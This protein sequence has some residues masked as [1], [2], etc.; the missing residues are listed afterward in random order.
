L[1]PYLNISIALIVFMGLVSGGMLALVLMTTRRYQLS[2]SIILFLSGLLAVTGVFSAVSFIGNLAEGL[3]NAIVLLI[4]AFALGYTLTT[5]SVLSYPSRRHTPVQK[6]NGGHT[7]VVCLAPGEPPSYGVESAS[8]RFALAEDAADVPPILL[9]P[10]YLRDLRAK[11]AS[12][13][14]SPYRNY[15]IELARK[16]QSRLDSTHKVYPAFY[17]DIPTLPQV[18][19]QAIEDGARRIVLIHVR[20]TDPPD[21]VKAGDLM[22]GIRPD[23]YD[24]EMVTAGPLYD[25]DLLPQI[26][27][28]RVIEAVAQV[29]DDPHNV[30]LLLVGRGHARGEGNNSSSAMRFVQERQFQERVRQA[31]VKV[32]FTESR[33]AVGWLRWNAPSVAE[34]FQG[35]VSAG[36]KVVLWMPSAFP[37]DG[38]ITLH[39]IPEQ[40][41]SVASQAGVKLDALG[42]WNAD[43]LTAE[44]VAARV[45]AVP[46]PEPAPAPVR[47]Q[48]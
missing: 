45:R 42:A 14:S 12:L 20:V 22:E 15:Y 47:S 18:V 13:G 38:V 44:E 6:G 19:T 25:S 30:G 5:F 21:A 28:R 7:V 8:R 4:L 1:I 32:G 3:A 46:S 27:V 39:D 16:V 29:T 24:I 26:Y 40:I 31:L 36:C 11:Y 2:F 48:R 35:L 37:A 33:V 10:F 9:R 23:N 17:N 43:D 41:S 34:A